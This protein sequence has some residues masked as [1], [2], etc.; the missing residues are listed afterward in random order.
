MEGDARMTEE[1]ENLRAGLEAF[2]VGD[3]DTA[4]RELE[5]ATRQDPEDPHTFSFLGAAYAQQGRQNLAI[6]ALKRAV[7]LDPKSARAHYN[8]AQACEDAGVLT[9]AWFE[10]RKAL[11]LDPWYGLA[12]GALAALTPKLE[13]MRAQAVHSRS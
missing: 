1:R 9:E 3:W 5:L 13:R 2:Q 10:Y 6:G 12:R 11:E 8:L 7:E 4:A